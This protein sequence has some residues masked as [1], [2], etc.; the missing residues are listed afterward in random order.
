M[1]SGY[2]EKFKM[3]GLSDYSSSSEDDEYSD[4]LVLEL[5]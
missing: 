4:P 2:A 3:A 1:V 5:D